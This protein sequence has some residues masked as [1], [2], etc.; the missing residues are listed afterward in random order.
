MS[1]FPAPEQQGKIQFILMKSWSYRKRMTVIVLL[2]V[3]GIVIEF[4]INFWAG[5]GLLFAGTLL[6][7]IKGYHAKPSLRRKETWNRVTPDEFRKV[8]LKEKQLK[9]WD[10]D[11]FDITNPLGCSV[12]FLFVLMFGVI[13]SLVTEWISLKL[14]GYVLINAAVLFVPHWFSGVRTYLKRDRLILK[15]E[16]LEKMMKHLESHSE[17]QVHPMMSVRKTKKEKQVPNDVRMMIRLIGAEDAFMGI[18]VQI[19]VN[20]VQGSD[21][22]YL[23]CVLLA[24]EEAGLFDGRTSLVSPSK[25]VVLSSSKSEGVDVLVV[26]Q[27]TTR[28][29]GYHTNEEAALH[30]IETAMTIAKELLGQKQS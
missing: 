23:Y 5:L 12:L 10:R 22:P 16:L 11:A 30:V 21:Y 20:N 24:R 1:L 27:K 7:M 29:S 15:I 28:K 26:R 9:A 4:L 19:A 2:M 8:K 3:M 13:F 6:G 17:I 25:K 14:A 18:Q